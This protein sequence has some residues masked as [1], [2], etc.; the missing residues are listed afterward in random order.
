[1]GSGDVVTVTASSGEQALQ[2]LKK[3][4][5]D[6]MILNPDLTDMR[7]VELLEAMD[8]N[9]N[10]SPLPIIIYSEQEPD[11]Q[12]TERLETY[13]QRIIVK[14]SQSLDRLFVETSLFLHRVESQLPA[15]QQK[16][17]NRMFDKK[18][19]LQ[20]K[21]VLIVDDDMRNVFAL[22]S[23]LEEKGVNTLVG[24]N[25]K[26]GLEKLFAQSDVDLVL[27]DIMMP[28][29]DGYEAMKVIRK[30]KRFEKLPIIALTAKA[31][32]GDRHKCVAAGASDYLAKPV[33][34]E[35]LLSL[36]RVWLYE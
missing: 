25:G 26:E 30:D 3:N 15:V 12:E 32:K 22:T 18:D 9:G 31:M 4:Q 21:K 19:A 11:P 20:G 34:P 29:M 17:L 27:M 35:K 10:I 28:V 23:I 6:A 14:D 8:N 2:L 5:F 36:L 16:I 7:G 1:M 33:A 24:K 13:A